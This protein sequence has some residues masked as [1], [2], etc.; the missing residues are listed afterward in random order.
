MKLVFLGTPEVAARVLRAILAAGHD[1]VGVVTRPDKRRGRGAGLS[2]SPVAE[3]ALEH[4]LRLFHKPEEALGLEAALG[5]VVAYGRLV[6]PEVLAELPMVNLHFSLLPRWRGAAPVE[7]AI[8][9]GDPVTGAC[10]MKLEEGLDTGPVYRC[11][12]VTVGPDETAAQ[13]RGRLG[14]LGTGMLLR[15]LAEGL[16]EPRAQVGEPTYA[17]KVQVDELRLDFGLP[18]EHNARLVRAGR[19][20]TTLRGRRLI[21]HRAAAAGPGGAPLAPGQLEGTMVGCR[22]GA[23][24][25]LEVQPEGRVAMPAQDWARGA[26]LGADERLGL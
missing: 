19:A 17:D 10:L 22:P 12:E 25:L 16:P 26:H 3:V 23:L 20:W 6:R 18:A 15:A 9:A 7:R 14:E 8:M 24:E 4:R 1:V 5:V 11:A 21:V 2:P 13:L